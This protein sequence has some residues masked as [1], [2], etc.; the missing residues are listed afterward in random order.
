MGFSSKRFRTLSAVILV[1][2]V[3]GDSLLLG[4]EYLK[5][6]PIGFVEENALVSYLKP[7][8]GQ[9]RVTFLQPD[10][11]SRYFITQV[12]P[13]HHLAFADIAAAPRLSREYTAY[14]EKIGADRIRLWQEFGVNYV[15]APRSV[16]ERL[17]EQAPVMRKV[18]EEVWSYNL[19]QT[20]PGRLTI[21]PGTPQSP[22][23]QLVLELKLPSDRYTLHGQ[24]M[25]ADDAPS[26]PSLRSRNE[27][28][29]D[30]PDFS[31]IQDL[32][33]PG[34]ITGIITNGPGVLLQ[35]QVDIP[36]AVLRLAD[37]FDPTLRA[38][39]NGGPWQSLVKVDGL[40]AGLEVPGGLLEVEIE[41][42]QPISA[43]LLQF[44]G[45]I[46]CLGML[47][48]L[49]PPVQRNQPQDSAGSSS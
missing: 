19:L 23:D 43:P 28:T 9:Q 3:M 36:R 18:L 1:A 7:R 45:L 46:L 30:D 13:A 12:F 6:A 26:D 37:K 2:T 10:G 44:G 42:H 5:P 16:I 22:G 39:I 31:A 27:I 34:E 47:I 4:R 40:F 33:S 20:G 11:I 15:L 35:L 41:T 24:A 25:A 32:R 8:L 14:F 49:T 21:R 17:W 38:R 29:M 48:S